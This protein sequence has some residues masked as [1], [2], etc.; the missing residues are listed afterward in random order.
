MEPRRTSPTSVIVSPLSSQ[1]SYRRAHES[2]SA[3]DGVREAATLQV[4]HEAPFISSVWRTMN[5]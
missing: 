5:W 1:V 3:L 2:D 4:V